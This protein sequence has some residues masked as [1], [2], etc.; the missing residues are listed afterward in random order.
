MM[1][2]YK[3]SYSEWSVMKISEA[4]TDKRTAEPDALTLSIPEK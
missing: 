3:K 2:E 4:G 1:S